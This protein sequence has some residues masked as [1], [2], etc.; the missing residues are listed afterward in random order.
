MYSHPFWHLKFGS[1]DARVSPNKAQG[2]AKHRLTT[3]VL[4][5]AAQQRRYWA[6]FNFGTLQSQG[7]G[8][9][10]LPQTSHKTELGERAKR[11]ALATQR[12]V[13]ARVEQAA[14]VGPISTSLQEQ[15]R[16]DANIPEIAPH[17]RS[18]SGERAAMAGR[19]AT[20]G[21]LALQIAAAEEGNGDG[22][23]IMDE[24]WDSQS[25]QNVC[26]R[27]GGA[28]NR[29][30]RVHNRGYGLL[31]RRGAVTHPHS[32]VSSASEDLVQRMIHQDSRSAP[33]FSAKPRLEMEGSYGPDVKEGKRSLN[34]VGRGSRVFLILL[35]FGRLYLEIVASGASRKPHR[36]CESNGSVTPKQNCGGVGSAKK[37]ITQRTCESRILPEEDAVETIKF[38]VG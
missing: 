30:K 14:P 13:Q 3:E 35:W 25:V 36:E 22:G 21:A 32:Q 6:P 15:R 31:R 8:P 33:I 7:S 9:P 27:W 1:E 24:A 29:S 2:Y 38:E 20:N 5:H 18:G 4:E 34:D 11:K 16:S 26:L 10:H 19:G 28:F 12:M 17:Y 37:F 23:G